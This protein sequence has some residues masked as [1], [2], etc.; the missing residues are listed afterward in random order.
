MEGDR[1][2]NVKVMPVQLNGSIAIPPSK[3]LSHR[4]LIAAGLSCDKSTIG[5]IM[6]SEDIDA[7]CE[8]IKNLNVNISMGNNTACITPQGKLTLL[9]NIIDCRESGSTLRFFIPIL[10]TLGKRIVFQGKGRLVDRPLDSYYDLFSNQGINYENDNGKLPL[11]VEGELK[12]GIFN[13]RGDISSQFITGLLF[14]LPLLKGDSIINVTS[15]LESKGYV[16]LTLDVLKKFSVEIENHDYKSF[17]IKGYQYYKPIDYIVEGDYSQAAFWLAAGLLGENVT[18]E[19]LNMNS[20]QGDKVIIDIIKAMDGKITDFH[21]SITASK[22]N[23]KGIEIDAAQC[24]D[25]IPILTVIG[26]LSSGTT[27]IYNAY[28]ARLKESDR[29]SAISEELIKLGAEIEEFKDRLI[30]KGK[31][32]LKGGV[33]VKGWNDHRIVMALAVAALG[34]MEPVIIEGSDC[35]AKSYPHFFQDFRKLGGE[36]YDLDLG[37]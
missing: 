17:E 29:L 35:I 1:M 23:L 20:L 34:C 14:A 15:N 36:V 7:T 37:L 2:G 6:H 16:D 5:N 26:A 25:L 18:C 30:I 3:S 27:T 31:S 12:P 32:K 10:L 19:N 33:V 28:R 22:S 8:V 24:P 21:N 13:I 9:N 4:A 11:T